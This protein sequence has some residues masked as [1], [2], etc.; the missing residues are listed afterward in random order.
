METRLAPIE[1]PEGLMLKLVYRFSKWQFGK[2]ITPLKVIYARLPISFAFFTQKLPKLEKTYKLP[3]YLALLIRTHVAQLNT[4]HFCIDIGKA[5]AMKAFPDHLD[6]FLSVSRFR[7]LS[8]F[9]EQ[10]RAALEFAEELTLNKKVSDE[11]FR[12]VKAYFTERQIVEMAWSVTHE[13]IYN[14]MN[15]AF[16]IG[17]DGLCQLPATDP[18]QHSEPAAMAYR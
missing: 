11:T 15:G 8:E 4:C 2:V 12:R 6:K 3:K 10:E 1:K 13:H 18:A 16:N 7:E 5:E 14:L 9:S 17:S